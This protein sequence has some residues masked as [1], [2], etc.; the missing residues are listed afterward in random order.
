MYKKGYFRRNNH[1]NFSIGLCRT[2][3]LSIVSG[4][5][6]KELFCFLAKKKP[7]TAVEN[8]SI[9]KEI[10]KF[11]KHYIFV[12]IRITCSNSFFMKQIILIIHG[13]ICC[14][15]MA[16]LIKTH[17]LCFSFYLSPTFFISTRLHENF[18]DLFYLVT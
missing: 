14:H 15:T 3:R 9:G 7:P 10:R 4:E 2:K 16:I 13:I 6:N 8:F 18:R 12:S 5:G 11:N 17:I 1:Q